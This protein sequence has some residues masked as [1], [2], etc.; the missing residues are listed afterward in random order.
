MKPYETQPVVRIMEGRLYDIAEEFEQYVAGVHTVRIPHP[1]S[2]EGD[3]KWTNHHFI[4]DPTDTHVFAVVSRQYAAIEHLSTL[5]SDVFEQMHDYPGTLTLGPKVFGRFYLDGAPSDALPQQ[6]LIY[7]NSFDRQVSESLIIPQSLMT[8]NLKHFR[9]NKRLDRVIEEIG[10]TF[11][12]DYSRLLDIPYPLENVVREVLSE[13]MAQDIFGIILPKDLTVLAED[14]D[15]AKL[16]QKSD[17]ATIRMLT[18]E[19]RKLGYQD[20]LKSMVDLIHRTVNWRMAQIGYK[21]SYHGHNKIVKNL[22]WGAE[23]VRKHTMYATF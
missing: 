14:A 1:N 16:V 21:N 4:M 15:E 3:P 20:N 19:V 17:R 5:K 6:G 18:R 11:L 7:L 2:S 23:V 13:S 10:R 22:V 9:G 8:V 12:E